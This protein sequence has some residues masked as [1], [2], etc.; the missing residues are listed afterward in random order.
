RTVEIPKEHSAASVLFDGN[1]EP[2]ISFMCRLRTRP[3][4]LQVEQSTEWTRA[5]RQVMTGASRPGGLSPDGAVV[6]RSV[7]LS[8]SYRRWA[9]PGQVALRPDHSRF[10][11]RS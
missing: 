6:L 3:T 8:A 5:D 2:P 7:I 11:T 10:R 9:G 1:A 4:S